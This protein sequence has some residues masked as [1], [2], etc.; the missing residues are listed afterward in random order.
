MKIFHKN[1][2]WIL[3]L[4]RVKFDLT[5]D[6]N[7]EKVVVYNSVAAADAG[8]Y[9]A[10]VIQCDTIIFSVVEDNAAIVPADTTNGFYIEWRSSKDVTARCCPDGFMR[11]RFVYKDGQFIPL[12][13]QEVKYLKVG[14]EK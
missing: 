1:K 2:E 6:G 3:N 4:S 13:E 8:S 14:K 5:G 12:Y 11:T 9:H 7:Q 10:D